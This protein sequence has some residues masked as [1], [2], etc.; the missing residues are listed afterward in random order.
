VLID[1]NSCDD[2]SHKCIPMNRRTTTPDYVLIGHVTHDVFDNGE[3]TIGGTASYAALTAVNLGYSVGL[4]T[5][6][7]FDFPISKLDSQVDIVVKSSQYTTVFRNN[8]VN[9]FR[10]Q[11]IYELA[12]KLTPNDL[13]H[14]WK[15]PLIAHIGPVFD[16]CDSEFLHQFHPDTYLGVTM[17][18]WLRA[19]LPDGR[20]VPKLSQRHLDVLRHATTVIISEDDILNDW[21]YAEK[22]ADS[23]NI[24]VVTCG[25]RGGIIFDHNKKL[26]F[27]APLTVE[28]SPTGAGDIFAAAFF[29][30]MAQG[31]NSYKASMFASCLAAK[32]VTRIGLASIPT[33]E[34]VRVCA[35]AALEG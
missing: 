22:L 8:Y 1:Y 16:E 19:R 15:S 28:K 29:C 34:E 35:I 23:T 30:S 11:I 5:S 14:N 32:S 9:G 10:Q 13:P 17:Q 33:K 4:L 20:I 26:S 6:A 7:G 2:I 21:D 12:S 24:L 3:L 18:G 27:S 31:Y 25:S